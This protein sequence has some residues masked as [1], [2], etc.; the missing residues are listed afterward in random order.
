MEEKMGAGAMSPGGREKAGEGSPMSR[1]K[2]TPGSEGVNGIE[3]AKGGEAWEGQREPEVRIDVL[4]RELKK[5]KLKV[6]RIPGANRDAAEADKSCTDSLRMLVVD[7]WKTK[8]DV[9]KLELK[10]I[11]A[12]KKEVQM[13]TNK[14]DSVVAHVAVM[15]KIW[16]KKLEDIVGKELQGLKDELAALKESIAAGAKAGADV[17]RDDLAVEAVEGDQVDEYLML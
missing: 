9:V 4:E 8:L 1:P 13:A 12:D 2:L 17:H 5:L 15:E 14:L 6:N 3:D 16:E 11:Y 10:H 7:E